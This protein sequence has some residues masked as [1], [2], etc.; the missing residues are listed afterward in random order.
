[1]RISDWSSDVCSSDLDGTVV[2]VFNGETYNFADIK[3]ELEARGHLFR[4]H[5]DTEVIVHGW[6]E[7]GADCVRRFRG[8]F[9]FALWDQNQQTLFMARDRLGKK[10]HNYAQL[11]NGQ[12]ILGSWLQALVQQRSDDRLVGKKCG[13]TVHSRWG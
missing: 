9:A 12:V 7:W 10:Q 13:L 5:C 2:V 1:M 3:K 11:A 8:M 4:T 6:E